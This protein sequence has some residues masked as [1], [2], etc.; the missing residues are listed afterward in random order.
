MSLNYSKKEESSFLS[1][2]KFRI[3]VKSVY[4][5]S[6]DNKLIFGDN[7]E[8]MKI[9]LQDYNMAGKIDLVYIDPPFATNNIFKFSEKR[10]STISNSDSDQIAYTDVL[11]HDEYLE[12]LFKRLILIREL[13]AEHSSI[14]LHIDYKIGHYVKILMDKIF[15]KSNFRND[16]TRIK[17]N[18]KNF[19]R[20]GYGNIK[21]LILFYSKNSDFVWNEPMAPFSDKD[22]EI[23]YPKIDKQ[24]R[25]YT[26]VPLHAPGETKIGK[27]GQEWNG[28]KPPIGRHWR[29][30]FK[31]LN[32]LNE[33]GLIEWSKNDNPRKIV[34]ATEALKKGKRLQDIW[35]FK[36]MQYPDYPTE[37]NVDLLKT[38]I[39]TSS[40]KNSLVFDCFAGSSTT[41][42]AAEALQRKWIGIDN[43]KAGIQVSLKKL[44][45]DEN[46]LFKPS[47]Q[48]LELND[49]Y[50]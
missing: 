25:R 46:Q 45:G 27:S 38:I 23:L 36:D 18:P 47:F 19:K 33:K 5:Q 44:I 39:R 6:S 7:F 14:Y 8:S 4:G 43:S 42:V 49:S 21:D 3:S 26:T 50:V 20:K 40:E 16:I 24:G 12:F 22:I 34:Y 1:E 35:D 17:C 31:I 28:I 9:L 15:G 37:K 11:N 2:T 41:L 29:Y 10:T 30:D 48:Y 32:E 13:M